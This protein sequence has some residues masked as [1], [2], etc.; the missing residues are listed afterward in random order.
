MEVAPLLQQLGFTDKEVRIYLHLLTGG[1]S[2][3]R[4]L[5]KETDLNRGSAYDA[6]KS[7]QQRGLV[8]F[9]QKHKKQFFLA[10]EP[11]RLLEAVENK[12][13]SI[14]SLRRGV[15]EVLPELKSL[16]VHGG[17]KPVVKYY[18]GQKGIQIVL[19]DVL[20]TMSDGSDKTYRVYSSSALRE[21]LYAEYPS[22]TQERVARGL[23]VRVV[24]IG[25]GG[26][27]QPLSERRW[28]STGVGAPTYTIIYGPKVAFISRDQAGA[29]IGV[30]VE[31]ERVAATERLLFEH[32]WESLAPVGERTVPRATA[33]AATI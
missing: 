8:G 30:L 2:S 29:L 20:R 28:L 27:E 15:S 25:P 31:D 4:K 9:F 10:E 23:R 18:E 33:T 11:E 7:L 13:R 14:S 32:V 17:N 21:F 26:D 24:A 5:A 6:L 3:V 22:F 19:K 1:P 12:E 16:Y